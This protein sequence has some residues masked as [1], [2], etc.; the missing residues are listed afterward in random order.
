MFSQDTVLPESLVLQGLLS[1]APCQ[2]ALSSALRV[3]HHDLTLE[4][5]QSCRPPRLSG[6]LTHSFPGLR[7][8]GLPLR[9]SVEA[10]APGGVG[11]TGALLIEAGPCHIRAR[12]TMGPKGRTKWLWATE[13]ECPFLQVPFTYKIN[14]PIL[15]RLKA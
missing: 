5:G 1:V 15:Q 6:T 4:L 2:L 13:S 9:T 8:R 7:I 14:Q 3:D 10:S 12:G 11:Q